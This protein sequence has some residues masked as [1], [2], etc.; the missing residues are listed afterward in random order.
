M[1]SFLFVFDVRHTGPVIDR[2]ASIGGA[3]GEEEGVGKAGLARRPM[4]SQGNV[5]DICDVIGRGQGVS[6]PV[7][8][9]LSLPPGT[10]DQGTL[11]TDEPTRAA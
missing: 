7:G 6:S 3:G 1:A 8:Y 9:G 10:G 2:P 4:S 11:G 5:A